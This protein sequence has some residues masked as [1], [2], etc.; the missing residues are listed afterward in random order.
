METQQV[1]HDYSL[2]WEA[3]ESHGY[4]IIHGSAEP[5]EEL[6]ESILADI[7]EL[8]RVEVEGSPLFYIQPDFETAVRA[9]IELYVEYG[10]NVRLFK[11]ETYAWTVNKPIVSHP[12]PSKP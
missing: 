1:R 12:L 8:P 7:T 10:I 9:N 2:Q 4:A 5:P 6:K 11:Y 3:M